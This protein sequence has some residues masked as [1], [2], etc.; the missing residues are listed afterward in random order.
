[1]CSG[2]GFGWI[3]QLGC[4]PRTVPD[5]GATPWSSPS[6]YILLVSGLVYTLQKLTLRWS[7]HTS[8]RTSHWRENNTVQ[9]EQLKIIQASSTMLQQSFISGS[10][11]LQRHPSPRVKTKASDT[12]HDKIL[13]CQNRIRT[14][15]TW[16]QELTKVSTLSLQCVTEIVRA[17]ACLWSGFI[18]TY[19]ANHVCW[20]RLSSTKDASRQK[21]FWTCGP[22]PFPSNWCTW[23]WE[24]Q[25]LLQMSGLCG[26]PIMENT[27]VQFPPVP[28][29]IL[30]HILLN[31]DL[32]RS[33][34]GSVEQMP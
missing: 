24:W 31:S 28:Q 11:S 16:D 23:W 25:C 19:H 18:N 21:F 5:Y 14:T 3:I 2:I 10:R 9:L 30:I 22:A 33:E 13:M 1:M 27:Q 26:F 8:I 4:H 6:A 15:S 7:A 17:E 29:K 34:Q 12:M 32:T 20:R